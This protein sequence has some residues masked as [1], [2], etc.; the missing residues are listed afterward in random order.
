MSTGAVAIDGAEL[1]YVREGQRRTLPLGDASCQR[2]GVTMT[3][4]KAVPP[5][6][7][8]LVRVST[9]LAAALLLVPGLLLAASPEPSEGI[10]TAT[11]AARGKEVYSASCASCHAPDLNGGGTSPPLAGPAFVTSRKNAAFAGD[12]GSAVFTADDLLF[13]IRTTMPR[14]AP[15]S[16]T[17]D[18]YVAVL[19]YILERNGHAAGKST[20]LA[21]SPRLKELKVRGAGEEGEAKQVPQFIK[22]DAGPIPAGAG[23]TQAE[24]TGATSSTR[25]W[26]YHTHDYSGSRFVE[27]DQ[28]NTGNAARLQPVCAFQVG[29]IATFQSGP[30]VYDGTMF[31]TTARNTVA[32]DAATCR[33]EWRYTWE[34]RGREVWL[35]N[36]GVA[37][38]DGRVIRGTSDGYLLA[39]HARTGKLIWARQAA[40]PALGETFTMPPLIYEDLII[41]GPAGSENGISGWVGAFRLSDGSPVWRFNTV[42]GADEPGSENWRH[43][44]GL[45]VGGGAVWTPMSFDPENEE[46]YVA[47]TNPAPDLPAHLRPGSNLY[48]NSVIALDV[49]SGKLRW[50]KQLVRN[51][52]HDWDLTQVSPLFETSIGGRESSLVATVG[53]EGVLRPIDRNSREIVWETAV[54]TRKNAD[55]PVNT[56]EKKHTCPGIQG[57]VSWNG[58]AFNPG[59]NRLY[60]NAI[61]WCGTFQAAEQARY[62]PGKLY[63]GGKITLDKQW[64]GWLT[65]LDASTGETA[66]K[67]RSPKP[68]VA[69]VTTSSGDV[70]FTGELTGDFLVLDARS[71]DVLYRFNTG[72]PL[73]GG[74]VTYELEGK[75]YVGA[76]SGR[77]SPFMENKGSPIVF[78]FALGE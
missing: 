29:E 35:N 71:G 41:I 77:P 37:V 23:P 68:M 63:L 57:G 54:T 12:W 46:L 22:G 2:Q 16:L 10:Y 59:T 27:L 64:Q 5:T 60:V 78:V 74:I 76:V 56:R 61:D 15:G 58:P 50:Y 62:L 31:L 34:A 3:G 70:V 14:S 43:A 48:T 17:D 38:K 20:L 8:N 28:I 55:R 47:V 19:A 26:L 24:L 11:Q 30:I 36:R 6:P 45:K 52:S 67:Y 40:N 69:A 9:R 65:A 7:T 33:Q 51:D 13:V 4:P 44:E 73:G 66:W 53:K 49:R 21:D 18:E 39:L 32:I 25:N 72:G 1:G 42:P 75:Q